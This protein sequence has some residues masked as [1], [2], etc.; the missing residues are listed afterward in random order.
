MLDI[1]KKSN[2]AAHGLIH[3]HEIFNPFYE[4]NYQMGFSG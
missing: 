3:T 1:L 2:Q 4:R